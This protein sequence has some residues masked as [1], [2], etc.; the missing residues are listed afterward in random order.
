MPSAEHQ[1]GLTK[2]YLKQSAAENLETIRRQVHTTA[3]G[4]LQVAGRQWARARARAKLRRRGDDAASQLQAVVRTAPTRRDF[5][6]RRRAAIVIQRCQRLSTRAQQL[7]SARLDA[8]ATAV[9][10]VWRAWRA[11]VSG[12][13]NRLP[14]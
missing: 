3:A 9:A 7:E 11:R 14:V 6:A 2:V 1:L 5:L 4:V 10:A 12:H 8:A 13:G